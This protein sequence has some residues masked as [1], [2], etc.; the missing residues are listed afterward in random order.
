MN[1]IQNS[2]LA[3]L[4]PKRKL[5]PSGW[6]SFNAPC[7]HHRSENADRRQRGGVQLDSN[8]S[9]RYHCFN[10]NFKAGWTPG[11]QLTKNTKDLFRWLGCGETDLSKL[12]LYALKLKDDQ[13]LAKKAISLDLIEKPLPNLALP[14]L[15]WLQNDLPED[16]EKNLVDIV[17]YLTQTRGMS[18][19]WYSWYWSPSPGYTDRIIIPFFQTDKIVGY[20]ARKIIDGKPKYIT[21]AQPGYV[22]NIDNQN[23]NRKYL[24]VVEGQFDAIGIDGCAIMHNEPNETQ[25]AR[26]K[27]LNKEVIIVPDRDKAGAK[28]LRAAIDNEWSVSVPPWEPFI[29]DVADAVKHYGRLYTLA[30]ILHYKESNKLKIEIIKKKLEYGR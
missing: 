18:I 5:T 13:P 26:L 9:F 14:L 7:C 10:C 17:S 19:D 6:T 8:G 16:I 3:L 12:N 22:F 27:S 4:P 23:T 28:L 24:I 15:E 11:H 20:T 25:I 1:L 2:L 30:T 21:D 29:K